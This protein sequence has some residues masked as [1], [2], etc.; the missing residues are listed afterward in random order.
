MRASHMM[1]GRLAA[2]LLAAG[3][4]QNQMNGNG[5]LVS[6]LATSPCAAHGDAASCGADG[7]NGC[8][9]LALGVAC[10]AGT[11]CPAGACVPDDPCGSWTDSA[12]CQAGP[13]CTWSAVSRLCPLGLAEGCDAGGFCHAQGS[14]G[15]ACVSPLFCPAGAGCPPMECDCSGGGGSGTCTC[16]CPSCMPGE[17]CAP[18]NCDCGSAPDAGC[19]SGGTCACACP[20][21]PAGEACPTCSCGCATAGSACSGGPSGGGPTT[22]SSC[23]CPACTAGAS[24]PPCDCGGADA[25]AADPCS[26]FT[27]QTA[28][29]A[30]GGAGCIW[31]QMGMACQMGQPCR[32]GVCQS[33]SGASGGGGGGGGCVCGCPACEPGTSCAPCSCS[34]EGTGNGCT[35]PPQSG[36]ACPA[37]GCFP[38]CPNGVLQD[39]NGC[40]TCQCR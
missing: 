9:W 19:V 10:P 3:C 29:A 2:A 32:D 23:T 7:A 8:H 25:G 21:C 30:D 39:A 36:T 27:D 17:S 4:G 5:K 40:D 11:A 26:P 1:N 38:N 20:V 18:C 13:G 6:Y 24:C 33:R 35:P 12:S 22:A 28:C 15:C 34:C 14:S 16:G 31:I 37:L